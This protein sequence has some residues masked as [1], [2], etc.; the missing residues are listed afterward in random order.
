MFIFGFLSWKVSSSFHSFL[1]LWNRHWNDSKVGH[2]LLKLVLVIRDDL[3]V[4]VN[5]VSKSVRLSLR[6]W[7]NSVARDWSL[8]F[9][10]VRIE[11]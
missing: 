7:D 10:S 5:G 6:D 2:T 11:F 9:D 8:M 4:W 3:L 1:L